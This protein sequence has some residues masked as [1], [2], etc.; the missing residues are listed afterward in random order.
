MWANSRRWTTEVALE[1]LDA[2][3]RSGLSL[4]EF[5]DREGVSAVRLGRWRRR[6]SAELGGAPAFIEVAPG[7]QRLGGSAADPGDPGGMFEVVLDSGR[8]VRVPMGFD[9]GAL[10]RLVAVLDEVPC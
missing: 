8:L 10:R 5:A 7:F 6:P 2:F 3:E 9:E 4:R 1:A